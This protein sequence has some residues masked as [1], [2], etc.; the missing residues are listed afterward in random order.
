MESN[1]TSPRWSASKRQWKCLG[2]SPMSPMP[3]AYFALALGGTYYNIYL[4]P[5]GLECWR[6]HPGFIL[7]WQYWGHFCGLQE[8][9]SLQKP[10]GPLDVHGCFATRCFE[11]LSP[12]LGA[13]SMNCHRASWKAFFSF[14]FKAGLTS[15]SIRLGECARDF[16]SIDVGSVIYH[17]LMFV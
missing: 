1:R 17:F 3:L 10:L 11:R 9:D 12:K 14:K 5:Q 6:S 16:A 15:Y 13:K 2:S 7:A 4:S 8:S